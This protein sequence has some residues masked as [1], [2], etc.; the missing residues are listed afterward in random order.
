MAKEPNETYLLPRMLRSTNAR[1]P[2]PLGQDPLAYFLKEARL[3]GEEMV[4]QE[5]D[6]IVEE[7]RMGEVCNIYS[8]T[9]PVVS[10]L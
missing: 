4:H 10:S 6:G 1:G 9:A 2:S 5:D 8:P 7:H 3:T